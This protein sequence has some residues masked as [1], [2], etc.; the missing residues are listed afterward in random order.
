MNT[1]G[2]AWRSRSG[3]T[4]RLRMSWKSLRNNFSRKAFRSISG[5]TTDQS[6]PQRR[7]VSG[8]KNL[9]SRICSSNPAVPGRTGYN[10]SFNGKLRDELLNVEI[11]TS[12]KGAQILTEKWR[13]E[14][15]ESRPHSA[16]N[17]QLPAPLAL[18]PK[19]QGHTPVR[20]TY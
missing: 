8:W 19:G 15:N 7:F 18:L 20:L 2:N 10:E 11:F 17:Y 16:L 5:L 9:K 13:R 14:Y 12:L 4:S 3:E 6:L 1:A